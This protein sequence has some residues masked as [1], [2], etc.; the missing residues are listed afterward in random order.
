M[1]LSLVAWHLARGNQGGH[2]VTLGF[3]S[4]IREVVECELPSCWRRGNDQLSARVSKLFFNSRENP[5]SW[6]LGKFTGAS[7][8]FLG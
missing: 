4:P 2:I 5:I 1:V 3:E 8:D 6:N 7:M